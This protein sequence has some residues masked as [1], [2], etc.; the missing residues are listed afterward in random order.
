[1]GRDVIQM[2][3]TPSVEF[4]ST[5]PHGARPSQTRQ[6]PR[7]TGVSIHA[8]AWGATRSS[9]CRADR[10]RCFNPR[11]RMGRDAP[12]EVVQLNLTTVSIHAPAWGATKVEWWKPQDH[13]VSIHAPAW[14][15]TQFAQL[16]V[17][18]RSVSIHAPAWGATGTYAGIIDYTS[19]F[20]PRARMGRD[21]DMEE[22]DGHIAS[23]SIHAPAWGATVRVRQSAHRAA[24]S[25]HA[26]AWGAT[27]DAVR[28]VIIQRVSIHA[29]AWGA[30]DHRLV[31]RIGFDVSIHAPAWGATVPDG[32]RHR[33]RRLVSIHAPAW[34]ATRTAHATALH[35]M[36]Q[37]TRPHGARPWR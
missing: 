5:R 35:P 30:T 3:L 33:L 16:C 19:G 12:A 36:F 37:S 9:P 29:P 28:H 21:E 26:P 34:G 23:V 6:T 31:K 10:I 27:H 22:K 25:I 7:H 2:R 11:A 24:V 17:Q 32:R 1:M 4:Q 8:P 18:Q 20:N 14:G 13:A 15:A